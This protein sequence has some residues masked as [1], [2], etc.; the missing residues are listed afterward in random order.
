[1]LEEIPLVISGGGEITPYRRIAENVLYRL[2]Q[3]LHAELRARYEFTQWDYTTDASRDE[4]LGHF[5]DRSVEAV[6]YSEG[7]IAIVADVVTPTS[8]LE[9]RRVYELARLGQVRQLWFLVVPTPADHHHGPGATPLGEFVDEIR[10]DFK[11]ERIYH[12]V[13]DEIDFQASLIFEMMPF[14]VRRTGSAF[15]LG[16]TRS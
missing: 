7:V 6:D 14:V 13:R 2:N 12:G 8:R 16:G 3:M 9:I 1:M 4:E 10:R 15:G 11:K 5:A